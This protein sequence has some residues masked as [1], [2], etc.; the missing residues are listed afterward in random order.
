MNSRRLNFIQRKDCEELDIKFDLSIIEMTSA[1]DFKKYIKD[2]IRAAA[3]KY[4]KI[5]QQSLSKVK[6]I[7]YPKLET[8]A[9]LKNP[10]LSW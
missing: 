5:K 8:Q 7:Q 6:D 2:E 4:L 10:L 9:Y 1:A 3:L